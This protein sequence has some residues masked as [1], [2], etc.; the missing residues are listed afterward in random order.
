MSTFGNENLLDSLAET[1][2]N[3][4]RDA[5]PGHCVRID[6]VSREHATDLAT[7][8][9]VLVPSAWVHVLRGQPTAAV[10]IRPEKAVEL[11]NRKLKP[12]LLLV[13]AGEGNSAS[14]LDNSYHRVAVQDLYALTAT[15]MENRIVDLDM[16]AS[17]RPLK[18]SLGPQQRE[19]WA[20]FLSEL[21]MD[22]TSRTLGKELWR[23]GLIPDLGASPESRLERNRIAVRAIARP[24]RPSASI[25]DRLTDAGM[26]DG[27]WRGALRL[28]LDGR[29][30]SLSNSRQWTEQILTDR[31]DFSFDTWRLVEVSDAGLDKIEVEPFTKTDGSVNPLSKLSL[32]ADGQ[33]IL[34]IPDGGSSPIGLQWKTDPPKV[35]AV[36]KWQLEVVPPSDL[37]TDESGPL[38][39]LFVNGDKRRATIRVSLDE[40]ALI[41]GSRFVVV[42]TA[43]GEFGETLLLESGE[44]ALSESQEFQ[45]VAGE[46]PEAK[47]RK[48]AAPSVPE[49]MVRAALDGLDDLTEDLVS[50]DLD[51]HAFGIRLGNRR[52]IQVRVNPLLI[53]LQRRALSSPTSAHLFVAT[54]GYGMPVAD[55]EE[56]PLALPNALASRRA[57]LLRELSNAPHRN[58]AE[59]AEWTPALREATKAYLSSFKRALD[60]AD[61]ATALDLLR[62]D[63]LS[64]SVRR[65]NEVVQAVV[66]LPIHPLRLSWISAHD[67]LLRGWADQLTEVMPRNARLTRVDRSMLAQLAPA[68]LPFTTLHDDGQVAVY[69]EELTFG[70]ALYLVPA[71]MDS[72]AMAESVCSVLGVER[73]SSTL[74]ASSSMLAERLG[75]Y[76]A[77]HDP[78]GALRLLSIN[79]GAGDLVGG[80]LQIPS[81]SSVDEE[82]ADPRR[83]E[84]ICYSD[85]AAY[86]HPVPGL[87]AAQVRL[88]DR[89]FARRTTHLT[90]PMSLS[91]R[92]TERI[93]ADTAAAHLAVI[94][95]LGRPV[96]SWRQATERKPSL[97]EMLVPLVTSATSQGGDL[98]WASTPAFG[99]S[100]GSDGGDLSSAH[101]SHQ[102]AMARLFGQPEGHVPAVAVTL[103]GERQARIRAAHS[104]ADWVIGIDRF[105][106][107][108]LFESG[109]GE[110]YIL[111]YAPDFVEGIGD[112]LTVTT[113]HRDEVERLLSRAMQDLGLQSVQ[114][115]VRNV[116]ETLTVVSG[117]LALRL[118][119]N[120]TLAREAVSLA[121]L[122]SHLQLRNELEELIVIPVDAH[123][124]VFGPSARG[125]GVARRCDLLLIRVSQRSF[126]IECV[127]VKSRK[128]AHL[129]QAL[130]DRITEQLE[131]TRRVLEARFF[132][133]PPR[134]DMALQRARLSSLLHYYAD[135]S[136]SHGLI[137]PD[138]IGDIHRYIDRIGESRERAEISMRGYVISLDGDAGFKKKYGDIPLTVLT[139]D[140]LGRAGFTTRREQL[141]DAADR[142]AVSKAPRAATATAT[143]PPLSSLD[144][145]T[146]PAPP[147]SPGTVDATPDE[148]VLERPATPQVER[149]KAIAEISPAHVDVDERG[150]SGESS[151]GSTPVREPSEVAVRLGQDA[152][153]AEVTWTVSTKGSPHAF[154]IG[155]P[156]QGKSVTTR[157][158]IRE[159]S[160]HSLPSLVF[161]FHGDMAADP[162]EGAVVLNAA[163]G[164]PFNP[165]EPD[166][167]KGRPINT[168]A[169]EIAEVV[170]YV[171]GLGEIQRNHVYKALQKVYSDHGWHG[172]E[173]GGSVPTLE[174]FGEALEGIEAGSAGKNA[175]ARLQPFT[176]FGVF[177]D[178]AE[179]SFRVLNDAHQGW[180]IDIS[181]LG[182]EEV[183]RVA[184]SFILRKVYREMFTWPQDKT[185]K[186][187]VVLDEAHRMAKDVTLPKIMKEGRKYG[188]GVIVASQSAD[189]FHRD[190]LGNAGTKIVF[191][192][193]YPASKAVGGLLR[194]RTGADVTQ[195]IEK[196]AVGAAYVSTP[197]IAQARK[198]YMCE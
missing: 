115:S 12:F 56:L 95:D 91:V 176:D 63:S 164:L 58:T 49:A 184:A 183:Q 101:R 71:S 85:S 116:L 185:M 64:L 48:T 46:M 169:W 19:A 45:V 175:R 59:S 173:V 77:A 57:D 189:D 6:D 146:S 96:L 129:P 1:I 25:D 31:P 81:E 148:Q 98:H 127:E 138:R 167:A 65:S 114:H 88:R 69:A 106:G 110:S 50:W 24:T 154:I 52:A 67:T 18:R 131:E 177:I 10:D 158:I 8:V 166:V 112:R 4:V 151:P 2:A 149:P 35:A 55:V 165:L 92:P 11:R 29:G 100:S 190:V 82:V 137:G 44:P 155:I 20:E 34:E 168:T 159:F 144:P 196:L 152:G 28:F 123:P 23:I 170:G 51:G 14:S 198:V 47:A 108:E 39:T 42:V 130:A 150:E 197:E 141:Q 78:G 68:N 40:D 147:A 195:E 75:A 178:T 3:L 109:L 80:A 33:L 13:P 143:A 156:G 54:T 105:V 93:L 97:D 87:A 74:R 30:A 70:A 9:Q 163:E 160:R 119:E 79:P 86:V 122:I 186:L 133:D 145:Q 125:E 161:D 73:M 132:S 107:V 139:A 124:E 76:Q 22:P 15:Q 62:L 104:R 134:I 188:V 172:L 117:R 32:G 162:P 179:S 192:T 128:E 84:V 94:Q 182:L 72:D 89:E 191:R 126:K 157:N 118:L 142:E 113:T 43:L 5:N 153:G 83:I 61:E 193:N 171:A 194:G 38:A 36:V 181:Q 111:D 90:P 21:V 7:R 174:E 99:P 16:R 53:K 17:L 27:P 187:A 136:A 66:L 37:R 102:R 103:D 140:D 26:S 121:A 120:S 60:A 41:E 135:R 180:V